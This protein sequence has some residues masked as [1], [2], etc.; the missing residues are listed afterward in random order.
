MTANEIQVGRK[1]WIKPD[2]APPRPTLVAKMSETEPHWFL[3]IGAN[4]DG[5]VVYADAFIRSIEPEPVS[6]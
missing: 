3:C 5:H 4:G 2:D 6:S 1:Y